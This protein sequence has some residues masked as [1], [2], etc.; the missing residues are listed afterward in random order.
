[1]LK[2]SQCS[3][4][5]SIIGWP[6]KHSNS[7]WGF[8]ILQ[9]MLNCGRLVLMMV[10]L[11]LS[12]SS[13]IWTSQAAGC[14]F[15]ALLLLPCLIKDNIWDLARWRGRREQQ[16]E[17]SVSNVTLGEGAEL[18][19]T[20]WNYSLSILSAT[21]SV[22]FF[23]MLQNLNLFLCLC[24]VVTLRHVWCMCVFLLSVEGIEKHLF[25]LVY[26]WIWPMGM[27]RSSEKWQ[28]MRRGWKEVAEG[29]RQEK[30]WQSKEGSGERG[31]IWMEDEKTYRGKKREM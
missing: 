5:H 6:Q 30:R 23:C 28:Q 2:G 11:A 26:N 14:L 22:D 8:D 29:K 7:F 1:M 20:I 25:N 17:S 13:Q 10:L 24:V 16:L 19:D 3:L 21:M 18:Q 4:Q 27:P 15:T 12:N 31:R 9:L